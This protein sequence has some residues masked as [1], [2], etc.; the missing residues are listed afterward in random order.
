MPKI[1]FVDG[2][3]VSK[4][5]FYDELTDALEQDDNT[6]S[7]FNSL[8]DEVYSNVKISYRTFTPSEILR[9]CEESLYEEMLSEYCQEVATDIMREYIDPITVNYTSFEIEEK[10]I[11]EDVE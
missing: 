9:N 3:E 8:L 2:V 6:I 5:Q 4:E 1:Y 10:E 7:S 11:D